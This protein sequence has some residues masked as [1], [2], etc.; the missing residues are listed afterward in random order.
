MFYGNRLSQ[1]WP[2]AKTVDPEEA[3]RFGAL[4]KQSTAAGAFPKIQG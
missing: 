2:Y 3:A 4:D 1:P